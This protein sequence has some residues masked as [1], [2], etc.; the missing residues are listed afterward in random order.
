MSVDVE[1]NDEQHSALLRFLVGT[2]TTRFTIHVHSDGGVGDKFCIHS[3][4]EGPNLHAIFEP[5]P[6][7][8]VTGRYTLTQIPSGNEEAAKDSIFSVELDRA[9]NVVVARVGGYNAVPSL[10]GVRSRSGVCFRDEFHDGFPLWGV[11]QAIELQVTARPSIVSIIVHQASESS[12]LLDVAFMV[13]QSYPTEAN[14][15][16]LLCRV[17]FWHFRERPSS[18]S[19]LHPHDLEKSFGAVIQRCEEVAQDVEFKLDEIDDLIASLEAS[20]SKHEERLQVL[21]ELKT[22]AEIGKDD[23]SSLCDDLQEV[24]LGL[25][26]HPLTPAESSGIT[27]E[28]KEVL[29]RIWSRLDSLLADAESFDAEVDSIDSDVDFGEDFAVTAWTNAEYAR[30]QQLLRENRDHLPPPDLSF[31]GPLQPSVSTL[32]NAAAR[33]VK[34]T[35]M[36]VQGALAGEP[37][38][39]LDYGPQIASMAKAC[40]RIIDDVFKEKR[41]AIE[42]DPVVASLLSDER[43]WFYRIP[44]SMTK[45]TSGD[46]ASVVKMVKK[47]IGASAAIKWNGMG[48]KRIAL[49]LFGGWIPVYQTTPEHLLNPL[50][51]NTSE[52]FVQTLPERLSEFQT[53]RNGFI[54]HDLADRDDLRRTWGCFQACLK[55]LLQAFYAGST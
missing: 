42:R 40:E 49:L 2:W 44:S 21:K 53:L 45:V 8:G 16:D 46:L 27:S 11:F 47:S 43:G 32:S 51:I 7:G 36:L 25:H 1:M 15:V 23:A 9:D 10:K 3:R 41:G 12:W 22:S 18:S 35:A 50:E 24:I 38:E 19:P 6:D 52:E 39:E 30:G 4:L 54:H 34:T 31:L 29:T 26:E 55:G 28:P 5:M 20:R 48:S 37:L 14:P 17:E 33:I 13:Q